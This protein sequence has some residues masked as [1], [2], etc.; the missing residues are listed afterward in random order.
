MLWLIVG[1]TAT[2]KTTLVR[3]LAKKGYRT[4]ISHTTRS[5]RR[6]ETPGVDYWY[7]NDQTMRELID[8]GQMAECTKYGDH[9]YGIAK[10]SITSVHNHPSMVSLAVV[11]G[12]GFIKL[13]Q[14]F[15][16]RAIFLLPPSK[17][18]LTRRLRER[19]ESDEFIEARL[20]TIDWE[21]EFSMLTNYAIAP[22]TVEN[23][24]EIADYL[25][26]LVENAY[27]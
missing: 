27:R 12:Y 14:I 7:V 19:G 9:Y 13:R 1:P 5:R 26:Q 17:L 24:L 22:D 10:S 2:G 16:Y 6:G 8:A 20:S 21:T 3:G 11:D 25:I 15:E 18:E 23:T 4:I